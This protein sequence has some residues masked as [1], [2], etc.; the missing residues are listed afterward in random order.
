M[1]IGLVLRKLNRARIIWIRYED[2]QN[3]TDVTVIVKMPF[4]WYIIIHRDISV[5]NQ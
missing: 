2:M 3:A 1:S 4:V 5:F